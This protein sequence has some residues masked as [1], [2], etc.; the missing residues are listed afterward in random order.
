MKTLSQ[1]LMQRA[2][3]VGTI[4]DIDDMIKSAKYS[5]LK[6]PKIIKACEAR[7]LLKI[8]NAILRDNAR[9]ALVSEVMPAIVEI[10]NKYAGKRYGEKTKEKINA[11]CKAA[12][13][14]AIYI[15]N[16]YGNWD[17]L[18]I[19]PLNE[20]GYS[21]SFWRYDDFILPVRGEGKSILVDNVIQTLS[22]DD[23]QLSDCAAY[24]DDVERRAAE[25]MDAFKAIKDAH[26]AFNTACDGF[27]CIIPSGINRLHAGYIRH[28]I[29]GQD[30]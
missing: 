22:I 1:I 24:V 16:R 18:H 27:N 17:D 29:D 8:E 6:E 21:G 20:K 9:Q 11:E 28:T 13:N 4:K 23:F 25:I 3:N 7:E 19:V 10:F 30:F 26:K 2:A 14:C 15:D 12:V 5:E